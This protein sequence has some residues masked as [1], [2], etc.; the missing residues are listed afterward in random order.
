MGAGGFAGRQFV[1]GI[2]LATIIEIPIAFTYV[3]LSTALP[4]SGGDYVF[5]S[6]VLGVGLPLL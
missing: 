1:L 2:I 3:W 5:Q 6:R 4:R